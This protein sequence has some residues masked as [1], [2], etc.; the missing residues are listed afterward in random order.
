MVSGCEL[1]QSDAGIIRRDQA[2]VVLLD[3][4]RTLAQVAQAGELALLANAPARKV[5]AVLPDRLEPPLTTGQVVLVGLN[6]LSHADEVGQPAPARIIWAN[7]PR[8]ELSGPG[9]IVHPPAGVETALDYEGEIAV[10]V[11]QPLDGADVAT[12]QRAVAA[13]ASAI[14]F[15]A[16]DIQMRALAGGPDAPGMADA[17]TFA[18]S[19]PVGPGLLLRGDTDS[20][21]ALTTRVNGER[22]Q[23]CTS[24]DM[25]FSPA[26]ILSEV[27][28]ALPLRPGDVVFTGTPAG[29]GFV[30]GR[31]LAPG[32]VVEVQLGTLVPLRAT[33]A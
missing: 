6:Y 29:V 33:V 22:R 20:A 16:R 31:R 12:A 30:S 17:K 32:D 4:G 7:L 2:G 23:S 1:Y 3:E 26:E 24:A 8:A 27:S 18:G 19:K 14:D 21:V 11:G 28:R 5:L 10:I 9:T 15:T 25:V 13:L